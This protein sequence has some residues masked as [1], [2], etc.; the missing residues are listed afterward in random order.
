MDEA[1]EM[2]SFTS[3]TSDQAAQLMDTLTSLSSDISSE[4]HYLIREAN[5]PHFSPTV[6][7][8]VLET[9]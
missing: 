3:A 5:L 1:L 7:L 8:Y 6:L 9:T 4:K 2:L